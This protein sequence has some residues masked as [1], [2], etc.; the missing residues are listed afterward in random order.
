MQLQKHQKQAA[1]ELA[2][3]GW[4]PE[5]YTS[6]GGLVIA[7]ESYG[8]VV[9]DNS[10][11]NRDVHLRN[12]IQ[13]ARRLQKDH[14]S[15]RG[16][17]MDWLCAKYEVPSDSHRTRPINLAEE[18]RA[19]C[20]SVGRPR[21]APSLQTNIRQG[22]DRLELVKRGNAENPSQWRLYGPLATLPVTMK[23]LP[24]TPEE[25]R[26]E[27]E[28]P[29]LAAEVAAP[30]SPESKTGETNGNGHNGTKIHVPDQGELRQLIIALGEALTPELADE[31]QIAVDAL[32]RADQALTMGRDQMEAAIGDVRSAL[33]LLRGR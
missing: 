14:N 32:T 24:A 2:E 21:S 12:V 11:V 15:L 25:P 6:H 7:H 1:R 5:G 23:E 26:V 29:E 4:K 28:P 9:V 19:F 10:P 31:R 20:T 17:F 16:K 22:N 3:D 33:E 13:K 30:V 8:H 18:C 27:H